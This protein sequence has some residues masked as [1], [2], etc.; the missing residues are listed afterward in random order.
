MNF[1]RSVILISLVLCFALNSKSQDN[2]YV[3]RDTAIFYSDSVEAKSFEV[4]PDDEPA[5]DEDDYIADTILRNNQLIVDPDSIRVL[6]KS[7]AFLYTRNLDS[8]LIEYQ[9]NQ[10]MSKDTRKP[11][12]SWLERFFLSPVTK[13][14]F[15]ILAGFFVSFILYKLFFT[16]VFFQRSSAK[17]NVTALPGEPENM[18]VS[19]DYGKLISQ[20]IASQ[21]YRL[22]VRYLY[23]QSLQNLS[24]K[25]I[26]QFAAD[27]TNYQYIREM[28]GKT[29]KEAFAALT[30]HY[31]YVWYGGFEPD[32]ITFHSIQD[33]FKQ[34][35]SEVK[36]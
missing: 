5:D 25:G 16:E 19:A 2:P 21:Q 36:R 13:Y 22:A 24:S 10:V 23:L 12:M 6:K 33:K 32:G 27:K 8:L 20:A 17:M 11:A 4:S 1:Y 31:E 18:F 29:F 34:F 26:I 15:W 7:K 35:N 14:F 30:L 3:Y 9:Q 28:T